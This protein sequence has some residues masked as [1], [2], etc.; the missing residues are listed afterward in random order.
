MCTKVTL[1]Q[2]S[3][4]KNRVLVKDMT[5]EEFSSEQ[6]KEIP[7]I[8][9]SAIKAKRC[10]KCNQICFCNNMEMKQCLRC[11]PEACY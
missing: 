10:S 2:G 1:V 11:M 8:V 9:S 6:L 3:L 7:I 4:I 5:H